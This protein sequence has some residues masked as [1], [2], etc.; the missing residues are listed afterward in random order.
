MAADRTAHVIT[1]V[2]QPSGLEAMHTGFETTPADLRYPEA[3]EVE[4]STFEHQSTLGHSSSWFDPPKAGTICIRPKSAIRPVTA[5]D[6]L[7]CAAA[8]HRSV[9]GL[10]RMTIDGCAHSTACW[11]GHDGPVVSPQHVREESDGE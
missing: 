4:G 2:I 8:E 9:S 11:Y 1:F 7:A 10:S 5:R 3:V 6:E